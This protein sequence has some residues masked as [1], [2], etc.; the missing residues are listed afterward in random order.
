MMRQIA[1]CLGL[2]ASFLGEAKGAVPLAELPAF[3]S[4]ATNPFETKPKPPAEQKP[5]ANPFESKAPPKTPATSTKPGETKPAETKPGE[6]KP[7]EPAASA[8]KP[9]AE[10]VVGMGWSVVPDPATTPVATVAPAAIAAPGTSAS[11]DARRERTR[12]RVVTPATPSPVVGIGLNEKEA[13][14]RD[15]WDLA[16]NR[17][18]GS[19]KGLALEG[20][21][22]MALS[23]DGSLF[24]AKPQFDDFV[25][26][27]NVTEGK[28][29]KS[30]PLGGLRL[31]LLA[32]SASNR[33]VMAE[34]GHVVV[35]S[36][37]DGRRE[38]DIKVDGWAVR[39]GWALSPGGKYLAVVLRESSDRN[40]VRFVDLTKGEI[41]GTCRLSGDP[42]D[43]LGI[44]ISRDGSRLA[45]V[46][47][48]GDGVQ[49][50]Q[51]DLAGPKRMPDFKAT[52]SDVLGNDGYQGP[53]VEWLPDGKHLIVAGRLVVDTGRGEVART[54]PPPPPSPLV[55]PGPGV[56]L[57]FN[58]RELAELPLGLSID[59][60][61]APVPQAVA[62]TPA[63]PVIG[64]P[65][66][67]GDRSKVVAKTI[68]QA[69]RWDARLA[70]P[71]AV[72]ADKLDTNGF[73]VPGG[74]IHQVLLA[75]GVPPIAVVSYAAAPLGRGAGSDTA[76]WIETFDLTTGNGKARVDFSFPTVAVSVSPGCKT[77][78]TL[79]QEAGGRVDLWSLEDDRHLGGCQPAGQ[80]P[81]RQLPW[82]VEFVDADHLLVAVADELSLWEVPAWK[83]V[84]TLPIGSIRPAL[85]PARDHVLV[86]VP[87]SNR[88]AV[89][90]C[91]TGE[92][93]GNITT[94]NVAGDKPLAAAFHHRGRWAAVLSGGAGGGELAVIETDSG[95][96]TARVRIPVSGDV[97]QFC[98][99]DHLLIDGESL[100]SLTKERV[101][102]RY[103]L[104]T[105]M[106]SR[107]GLGGHHWYV[108]AI[109]PSDKSYIVYGA[110]LPEDFAKKEIQSS[111]KTNGITMRPTDPIKVEV[112]STDI[113]GMNIVKRI[114]ETIS[115][116]YADAG[117]P[118]SETASFALM[119]DPGRLGVMRT[120]V[121]RVSILQAG[122]T[123]WSSWV[124][125]TPEGALLLSSE[126]AGT[127]T[128]FPDPPEVRTALAGLLQLEPPKFAFARGAAVGD[129]TSMLTT[130]GPRPQK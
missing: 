50:I 21:R 52:A 39:D 20:S 123:M 99:D 8:P 33:L 92:V 78:A 101:V 42:G 22:F 109:N 6:K 23:P 63:A 66:A 73:K 90:E 44:A 27:F 9:A 31:D 48:Q 13:D 18:L 106:H 34:D 3:L 37:P 105:G 59:A 95:H 46:V 54:L 88:V 108:A 82:Y 26:V 24:A 71:P 83:Q 84:Y 30:I 79:S 5:A 112:L 94:S 104:T 16:A 127:A 120:S 100:V 86:A 116:R 58:G 128:Q 64:P 32:F 15:V 125:G 114:K 85:S 10:V 61:A 110:S 17:K 36:L 117:V 19:V 76:A 80:R 75:P 7:M 43:A 40:L 51:V 69:G 96:E 4:Q 72:A 89:I 97:L 60:A 35:H 118:V 113:A 107:D 49:V 91:L 130:S 14:A 1:I 38:H 98:D 121:W 68:A 2:A 122:Q 81:D 25:V 74:F 28:M 124:H 115:K 47:D 12:Y 129:G 102:W 87:D 55:S 70:A 93:R 111:S 119:V 103:Q 11:S 29:Q 45:S 57:A 62:S 53:V 56:T 67:A 41:A 65:L 77:V 126:P